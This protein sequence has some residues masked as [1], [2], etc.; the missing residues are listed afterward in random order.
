MDNGLIKEIKKHLGEYKKNILE[1][2]ED[3]KWKRNNKPYPHILPEQYKENNIIDS[4]YYRKINDEISSKN[5]KLHPDFHHLNS[6]QALCF[7]LF[8][9]IFFENKFNLLLNKILNNDIVEEEKIEKYGFE[10]IDEES[11]EDTNFDL[12]VKTNRTKYYFEIKYTEG[13]F[14]GAKNNETYENIYNNIYKEKIRKIFRDVPP[15]K[16][17]FKYYQLFRNLLYNDGYNIFVFPKDRVDLE[18]TINDVK[19]KYCKEEQQKRIVILTIEEI[20]KI[21]LDS[22]N[23]EIIDH[24]KK[25]KEKYYLN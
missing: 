18:K 13:G 5:I 19:K 25:F 17:F 16:K 14:G 21:M 9:P 6:S 1:I 12:Y 4:D 8:F 22:N 3:G 2:Y 23:E 24:Y 7:N 15:I 10:Y 20:V 11:N